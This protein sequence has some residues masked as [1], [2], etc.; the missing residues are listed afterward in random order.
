MSY[1]DLGFCRKGEGK[2]MIRKGVTNIDGKLPVNTSGGLKA[3]GHPI[4]AT[5]IAQVYEL[6]KQMRN[7]AGERQVS[8][9]NYAL[10]HNIGGAGSSISVHILK[11]VSS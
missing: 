7:Q 4:T 8:N 10:S 5:G 3:K 9:V 1:E 2:D 11:K 6:V